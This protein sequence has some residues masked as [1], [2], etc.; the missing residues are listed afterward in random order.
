MLLQRK[1]FTI[2]IETFQLSWFSQ[3]KQLLTI[4]NNKIDSFESMK[5]RFWTFLQIKRNV[6]KQRLS[7]FYWSPFGTRHGQWYRDIKSSQK[8]LPFFS[9][10]DF[11]KKIFF[12]FVTNCVTPQNELMNVMT[13]T[14]MHRAASQWSQVTTLGQPTESQSEECDSRS[15]YHNVTLSHAEQVCQHASMSP[16]SL[17]RSRGVFQSNSWKHHTY[18]IHHTFN[19][20]LCIYRKLIVK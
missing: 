6:R 1:Y 15:H 4:R 14:V 5:R 16:Q 9:R 11:N 7:S 12:I 20:H 17:L 10:K 3:S 18:L 19:V 8:T 2:K 13:M